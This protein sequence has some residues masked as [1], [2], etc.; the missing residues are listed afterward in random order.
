M[1][2]FPRTNVPTGPPVT[3][4]PTTTTIGCQSHPNADWLGWAP[5]DVRD[6]DSRAED[7]WRRHG[8]MVCAL[9][10]HMMGPPKAEGV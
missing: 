8:E 9:I 6:F 4:T 1:A 2:H 3:V 10:R 7:L 5:E